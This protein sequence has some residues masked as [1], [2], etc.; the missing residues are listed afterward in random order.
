MPGGV[1]TD[2]TSIKLSAEDG[3]YGVKRTDTDA[4]V[5]ADNTAM[6]KVATGVY[7]YSFEDP[8][9]GLTY[10]YSVEVVYDGETY[11]DV[12]TKEG[13][14]ADS[15]FVEGT[16]GYVRAQFVRASL[17]YDL[18]VDGD[19]VANVDN[20]ANYFIN[21]GQRWLDGKC[22]HV[23][24][25]SRYIGVLASGEY[26]L[27]V[28]NLL[29][30]DN[31]WIKQ[32][33]SMQNIVDSYRTLKDFRAVAGI[34]SGWDSG[35]P[36]YWTWNTVGLS[37]EQLDEDADSLEAAG[38]IDYADVHF[39]NH[40]AKDGLL[41]YPKADGTYTVDVEGIFASPKLVE[42][43]DYSYW[44]VRETDLLVL[45]ALYVY[46]GR[47]GSR[48]RQ[49]AQYAAAME[50]ISNLSARYADMKLSGR[51]LTLGVTYGAR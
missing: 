6:N 2:P 15:D 33:T 42:D 5:V 24:P 19:L 40:F 41:F 12:G 30:V 8:T 34:L 14:D 45:A 16:L 23:L 43:T 47:M 13:G 20:G 35:I 21:E 3:S 31:L 37:P 51:R 36:A 32:G 46:E 22:Y 11:Y 17:R 38:A 7:T 39:G 27:E 44:T 26:S 9:A 29:Y 10:Q 25:H 1:L 48:A 4:V 28:E 18:V 49:D 50:R